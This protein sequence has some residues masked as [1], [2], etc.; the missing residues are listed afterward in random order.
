MT[1]QQVKN[2]Q[3]ILEGLGY[4]PDRTD[5]Y[6][7][8]QTETAVKAFQ[9]TQKLSVTGVVDSKTAMKLQDAYIEMLRKPENDLQLR[10]AVETLKKEL[11]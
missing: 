7:S 4:R 6:Y 11:K 9:R 1:S 8:E 10:V 5:G 3:L 2:L